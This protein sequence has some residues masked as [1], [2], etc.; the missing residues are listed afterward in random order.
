VNAELRSALADADAL[1]RAE[2]ALALARNADGSGTDALRHALDEPELVV[3]ALD[4]IG[5][6][7]LTR[8]REPVATIAQSVLKPLVLKVAAARALLRMQDARGVAALREVLRAFRSVGRSYAVQ[9]T[10]E[11][12]VE[13]L[14]GELVRLA[15]RLR[16]TDPEV[17]VEALTALLPSAEARAGLEQLARRNDRAGEQAR[18][19]LETQ[20]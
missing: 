1:V 5:A 17:L 4:A 7:Q 16:G 13:E 19:A 2:A 12:R 9:V 3:E 6:L 11:L 10:G 8:L 20:R 14:A 15:R 18:A